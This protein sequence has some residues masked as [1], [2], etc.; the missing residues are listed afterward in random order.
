M[1]SENFDFA[2]HE[3]RIMSVLT[4]WSVGSIVLGVIL[5]RDPSEATRAFAGQFLVWGIIDLLLAING[6]R[7][8]A[9]TAT[10]SEAETSQKARWL[11][12][13]FWFNA[14]LNNLYLAIGY[15]MTQ[16][17]KPARR[18]AGWGVI[19]QG[20]FLYLFDPINALILRH[21]RQ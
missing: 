19:I 6:L 18:G 5:R 20:G 9:K 16:S 13:I 7:G 2:T 12:R 11:E 21:K 1:T 15:R 4:G 8:N 3:R 10:L 17:E 14:V